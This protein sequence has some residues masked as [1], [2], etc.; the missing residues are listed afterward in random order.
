MNLST[1]RR[2]LF[3]GPRPKSSGFSAMTR[4]EMAEHAFYRYVAGHYVAPE[5]L[6][7]EKAKFVEQWL[8]SN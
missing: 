7:E 4:E 5:N 2:A 6:D 8:R 3:G 1:I